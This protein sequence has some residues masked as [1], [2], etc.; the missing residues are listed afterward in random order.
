MDPIG[1]GRTPGNWVH[2]ASHGASRV[3]RSNNGTCCIIAPKIAENQRGSI[4]PSSG[5]CQRAIA[6]GGAGK[7]GLSPACAWRGVAW[8]ATRW[9]M[10]RSEV[11]R[12]W[13]R[14]S[15][16]FY[17]LSRQEAHHPND[18]GVAVCLAR[19]AFRQ[20]RSA[21]LVTPCTQQKVG[22]LVR[23]INCSVESIPLL[24]DFSDLILRA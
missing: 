3:H 12:R 17:P 23:G 9:A 10:E 11:S 21:V 24:L 22:G 20:N 2:G 19:S 15:A 14:G 18:A 16:P 5:R 4:S 8:T 13:M 7:A 1:D 6:H